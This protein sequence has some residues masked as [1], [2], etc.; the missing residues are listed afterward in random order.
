MCQRIATLVIGCTLCRLKI[1]DRYLVR[2][3]V[4]PSL[5]GLLVLTFVLEIPPILREGEQLIAKGVE[6]STVAH[7][8][9]TLLPQA[10]G[11]TIPM[12]VLLGLLIAFG[13]LSGDREFVALQ[14]CGISLTRL[15]RPV[16]LIA[17][18]GTIATAYEM[19]VALPNANQEF[20][21]ITVGLVATRAE[22]NI[23]PH[24]F[25]E[26]FPDR[27]VYVRDAV[28]GGGWRDVFLADSSRA[29]QTDVYFAKEGRL[30]VDRDKQTVQLQLTDGTRHTINLNKP[31]EYQGTA[32]GR[33]VLTVDPSTVFP[34]PPAKGV[35]ENT[36]AEL[37]ADIARATGDGL[38]TYS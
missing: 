26:E 11:L 4:L 1:L 27:I 32:F 10:L 13:R 28:P 23:K 18:V 2:E 22:R 37:R 3:V 24:L 19:I 14:A 31:D 5:I 20:R 29:N 17:I 7:V 38:P 25:F 35:P 15:L 21:E 16:A 34:R 8:L 36:I 30:V 33:I 9:L 6:L 12:A